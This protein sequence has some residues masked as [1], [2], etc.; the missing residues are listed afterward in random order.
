MPEPRLRM[1]LKLPFATATFTTPAELAEAAAVARMA[2]P[3]GFPARQQ[4]G[5]LELEVVHGHSR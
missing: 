2:H 5:V 4:L 1:L 3:Q